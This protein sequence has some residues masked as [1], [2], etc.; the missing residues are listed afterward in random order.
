MAAIY[1]WDIGVED[2]P[3][4]QVSGSTNRRR[5]RVFVTGTATQ[6][7]TLDVSTY[8]PNFSAVE[9]VNYYSINYAK[10][11]NPTVVGT[12]TWSGSTLT[13]GNT[14]TIQLSVVGYTA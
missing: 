4:N 1:I 10:A 8:V 13:F 12:V 3:V 9:G 7:D 11:P 6:S 2:L 5:V 14:G